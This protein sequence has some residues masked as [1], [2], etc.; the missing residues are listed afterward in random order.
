MKIGFWILALA[1]TGITGWFVGH[2]VT[3]PSAGVIGVDESEESFQ[4]QNATLRAENERLRTEL[5]GR[6]PTLEGNADVSESNDP[7]SNSLNA[8][9]AAT[10][11]SALAKLEPLDEFDISKISSA[12]EFASHMLRYFHTQLG[13]GREG[14]LALLRML[15]TL[16][17]K[18]FKEKMQP[19]FEQEGPRAVKHLYPIIKYAVEH[20]QQVA[21]LTETF[22]ETAAERPEFF[23]GLDDDPF[24]IFT[25]GIGML[26]PAVTSRA[27]VDR[28]RGYAQAILKHPEDQLP[29]ALSRNLRD[30]RRLVAVWSPPLS[31]EDALA[32]L[33]RGDLNPEELMML[34][35]QVPKEAWAAIDI[36]PIVGPMIVKSDW[37]G[38]Q[39]LRRVP[40]VSG[41][42]IASIDE[43][44]FSA[45]EQ[46][47]NVG[48]WIIQQYLQHS[49]R[50]DFDS[51]KSFLERGLDGNRASATLFARVLMTYA[52]AKVDVDW[53]SWALSRANLDESMK[54]QVLKHFGLEDK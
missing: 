13:K 11:A 3:A 15:G 4:S 21:A 33:K 42:T 2:H 41:A 12:D 48:Q 18:E 10:T 9:N 22:F 27:R 30:I 24:E 44:I 6:S 50:R 46:K 25:E 47:N 34:L 49:N 1:V 5:A 54:F 52:K 16:G 39:I 37:N 40:N 7:A 32:K 43:Q 36:A 51:A 31:V 17:T 23:E 20:D 19:L 53:V 28:M 45:L 29:K 35:P 38:I 26:M 8:S 14:H